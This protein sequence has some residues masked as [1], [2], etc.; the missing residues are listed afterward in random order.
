[1]V[2]VSACAKSSNNRLSHTAAVIYHAART[3]AVEKSSFVLDLASP[4]L[5]RKCN[6]GACLCRIFRDVS[7]NII[8]YIKV[9]ILFLKL[10]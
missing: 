2:S 4:S 7:N 9:Q 6:G 8:I 5:F 1:M 10:G 3:F